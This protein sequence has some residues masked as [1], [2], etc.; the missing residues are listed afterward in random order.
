LRI[1]VVGSGV[2]GLVAAWLLRRRHQVE[3]F[4][5]ADQAGGHVH[6][7]SIPVAGRVFAVD[8]GFIV[9]NDRTYPRFCR[10]LEALEVASDPTEM[11]FSVRCDASGLEY[12][13]SSFDGL[14]ADRANLLRPSFLRM[15][16]DI[17]RFWRD[18][19]RLLARPDPK[20][21][22][23]AFLDARR[24]SRAFV[25]AH[26][27]PMGAAIWSTDARR[28]REFPAQAFL[29]FLDNHGLL[30]LRNRPQWR[31]VRGGS[32]RYVERLVAPMHEHLHLGCPV[33][34]VRRGPRGV[35]L[36]V[37]DGV[38]HAFDAVVFA[39]HG[40]QALALLEDPTPAERDVLGA[41]RY[42][43]NDVVLHTDASL[44]PRRR[45]AW[46][47]W[48]Y[49]LPREPLDGV[50]LTYHMN[51]LQGL[52]APVELCVTL[53]RTGAIRPGCVL[54]RLRYAH[55]LYDLGT[56]EAQAH[57]AAVNGRERT[58][59]CGAYWYDGFHEDGVRSALD[60]AAAFEIEL[61]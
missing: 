32:A 45:R 23:G 26:L 20:L 56:L 28:M 21:T 43:P 46:A 60:V 49:H 29:R 40:D 52:E 15:L 16:L 5:A 41:I 3:I 1:A 55:P 25:E 22:L 37:G 33:R 59:Y 38:R 11:S 31:V 61:D 9:F 6:T 36:L 47:S 48:N 7:V 34:R 14:F 8:T 17:P 44:L 12:S 39:T 24:Y 42:Q 54:R 35:E 50:A 51:R 19:R 2:S 30:Q 57:R 13:G 4:E 58:W 27:L 53:N 18:A 10:L